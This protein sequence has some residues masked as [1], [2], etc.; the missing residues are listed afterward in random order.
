MYL[1]VKMARVADLSGNSPVGTLAEPPTGRH[2][3][4]DHYS[5]VVDVTPSDTVDLVPGARALFVGGAGNLTII[6]REGRTVLFTS[7]AANTKIDVA[8]KRV[9]ATGTVATLIQALY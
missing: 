5:E 8:A 1:E 9:M 6:T 3:S 2:N 4:S 7:V